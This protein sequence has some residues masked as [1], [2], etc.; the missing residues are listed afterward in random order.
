[1]LLGWAERAHHESIASQM[2]KTIKETHQR[3]LTAVEKILA[4]E[5]QSETG[6]SDAV[7]SLQDLMEKIPEVKVIARI[8]VVTKTQYVQGSAPACGAGTQA[9]PLVQVESTGA[10]AGAQANDA[11]AIFGQDKAQ[12][13]RFYE[14]VKEKC[15]KINI[16]RD[17]LGE[18]E[19]K[20]RPD[21][22]KGTS[23]G[24]LEKIENENF[25][26]IGEVKKDDPTVM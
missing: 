17:N 10:G 19:Y 3:Q 21:W 4:D 22:A 9:A 14:V 1:M 2:L 15:P 12:L 11:E 6:I 18:H 8:E 23:S 5:T 26:Y 20:E 25:I 24:S 7:K 13:V 16:T